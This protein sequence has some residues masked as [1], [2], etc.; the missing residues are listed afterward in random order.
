MSGIITNEHERVVRLFGSLDRMLSG[1]E[2]LG[3]R[4]QT[5]IRR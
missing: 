1:I 4:S 2:R 3:C 5:D